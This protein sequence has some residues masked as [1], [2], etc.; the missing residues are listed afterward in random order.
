ML[1]RIEDALFW[2][3]SSLVGA[4][5]SGTL[6][7]IRR[8]ITNQKQIELLQAELGTREKQRDEDRERMAKIESG[9]E[10]IEG[11]LMKRGADR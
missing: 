4:I 2:A 6:W 9:V 8:V 7:L 10:R 11:V 5:A 1:D 3:V